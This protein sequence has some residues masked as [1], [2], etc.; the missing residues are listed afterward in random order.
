MKTKSDS[1]TMKLARAGCSLVCM[2]GFAWEASGAT[3]DFESLPGMDNAI[4][5]GPAASQLSD[6]FLSTLGV[7][8]SSGSPYVAVVNLGGYATSGINAVGGSTPGGLMTYDAAFPIVATFFDPADPAHPATTDR[9]SLRID[10]AGTSGLNVSLL[11]FDLEGRLI[12]SFVTPDVG[13]ATL[14]VSAPGIHSVQFIGT[15]DSTGAGIDDF[16]FDPV[17]PVVPGDQQI[18]FNDFDGG[19]TLPA[20]VVDTLS[21]AGVV[22]GVQG[23]AGL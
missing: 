8:F 22:T 16:T 2:L 12:R 1:L 10:R 5:P 14:E 20:G 7:R 9:V 17:V 18:Y 13:G 21:G 6:Q 4:V 3:I 11:A 15:T 19:K 23:Y